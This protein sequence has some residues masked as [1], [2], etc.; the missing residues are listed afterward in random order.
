MKISDLMMIDS[1]VFDESI[2][3]K[4]ALFER[5]AQTLER[6]GRVT[7]AKKFIKDL[8]K[9]EEETSTGIE[10]G[11]GIP[12][13][14]S[15]YVTEPTICFAHTAIIQ[16]YVGLDGK[17]IEY[18]FMIT[19]PKKLSDLHLDILSSLSRRLIDDE[20]RDKLKNATTAEEV[21]NIVNE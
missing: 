19:V 3:S 14:K 4:S 8:Y 9:R 2:Q 1:I 15:K 7:K 17:P 21:L 5:L 10:D 11:F 12:H 20:F 16:D 6:N 18:V 13:A